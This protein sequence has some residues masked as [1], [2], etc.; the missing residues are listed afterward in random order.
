MDI[1]KTQAAAPL[2]V[3]R[4]EDYR[5]PSW[6]APNISLEFDL[7]PQATRVKASFSVTR[8]GT[9]EHPLRLDGDGLTP[10]RVAVDGQTLAPADWQ[11][12]EGALVIA[13]SGDSHLIETEV[14]ITPAA[15]TQLMGL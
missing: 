15:N 3:I 7:D 9:H 2:A 12:D 13:L 5:P 6:L 8:S 14:E 4:R 11:M 10:L 1:Q